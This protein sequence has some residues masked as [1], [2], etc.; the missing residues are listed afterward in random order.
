MIRYIF[1]YL[2]SLIISY[3][4]K[5]LV[6]NYNNKENQNNF[7]VASQFIFSLSKIATRRRPIK[8]NHKTKTKALLACLFTCLLKKMSKITNNV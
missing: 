2:I 5:T 1:L 4:G 3:I 6:N 7:H 8:H